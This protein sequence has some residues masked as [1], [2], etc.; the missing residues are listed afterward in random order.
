V[1]VDPCAGSLKTAMTGVGGG[2]GEVVDGAGG[3]LP[4]HPAIPP[5][6]NK[7]RISLI[8]FIAPP[9]ATFTNSS[10]PPWTNV[11]L[12]A[13]LGRAVQEHA[14]EFTELDSS[15]RFKTIAHEP[16]YQEAMRKQGPNC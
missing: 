6:S 13:A 3:E 10:G 15:S 1:K 8:V 2:G 14:D 9:G 4:P 5:I 16:L 11:T 12:L 7:R